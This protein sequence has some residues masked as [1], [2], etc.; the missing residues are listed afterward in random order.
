MKKL[1]TLTALCALLT[2]PATAVQKCVALDANMATYG[3]DMPAYKTDW[4]L[5][6][7]NLVIKGIAVCS[8]KRGS[9]YA[10]TASELTYDETDSNNNYYCWCRMISPAVSLWTYTYECEDSLECAMVCTDSCVTSIDFDSDFRSAMF[11]NLSN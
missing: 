7:E 1:L 4:T 11:S 5:N 2:A 3:G 10:D 9:R 8:N 6:A